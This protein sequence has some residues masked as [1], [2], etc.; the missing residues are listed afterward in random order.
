MQLKET[1]NKPKIIHTP[2]PYNLHYIPAI[3]VTASLGLQ[4]NCTSCLLHSFN[5]D[6]LSIS[7]LSYQSKVVMDFFL[8]FS[9]TDYLDAKNSSRTY[10]KQTF[11]RLKVTNDTVRECTMS[12]YQK[13]EKTTL[14][15]IHLKKC[16]RL[17]LLCLSIR[18]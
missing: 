6:F 2:V 13:T 5:H 10:W 1:S 8:L 11:S 14:L 17:I 9:C 4:G 18:A 7:K 16:R 15:K 12:S 3:P